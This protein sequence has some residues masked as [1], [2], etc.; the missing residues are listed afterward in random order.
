MA[1]N[2]MLIA[3]EFSV[4][5]KQVVCYGALS[6]LAIA[7]IA[8]PHK[9]AGLLGSILQCTVMI[10][11][12]CH[13]TIKS[14]ISEVKEKKL[15]FVARLTH[16]PKS[17]AINQITEFMGDIF[18]LMAAFSRVDPRRH[19]QQP[20]LVCRGPGFL[21]IWFFAVFTGFRINF[22]ECFYYSL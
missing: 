11:F 9:T 15:C 2:S 18:H 19:S 4:L 3:K 6:L 8:I 22:D 1:I 20:L 7:I 13:I 14:V 10:A 17:S 5:K 12:Y 21:C 16:Y